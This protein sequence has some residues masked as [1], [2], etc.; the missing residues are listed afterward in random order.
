M[1]IEL[2][3]SPGEGDS[4]Y[5]VEASRPILAGRDRPVVAY[6]AAATVGDNWLDVTQQTYRGLADV[7]LID[8]E[9]MT[10]AAID[11]V[12]DHAAILL[13]SGGNTFV[14][15]ERLHRT[16]RREA[17]RRRMVD[18][19]PTIAF[20]AGTNLCGAN[21]LTSNDMNVAATTHFDGLALVRY[22]FNVHYPTE[23]T[24]RTDR[25]ERLREYHAFQPNPILALE[26]G[27][28]LSVGRDG[29]RVRRG[30]CWLWEKGAEK[31]PLEAGAELPR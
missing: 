9:T 30:R 28:W 18:G 16:S 11:A 7:S 24:R 23:A 26:D 27:A 21:I 10:A 13:V 29:V 15:N 6:L 1:Q 5:I 22:S 20:S 2:L 25:D 17:V 4:R 14:L 12:L 8:V 19:L 3:S 31:R